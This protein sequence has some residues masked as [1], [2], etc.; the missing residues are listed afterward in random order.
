M[1]TVSTCCYGLREGLCIVSSAGVPR[2]CFIHENATIPT[3][4]SLRYLMPIKAWQLTNQRILSASERSSPSL[5][6]LVHTTSSELSPIVYTPPSD[7]SSFCR[8]NSS[9]QD[10]FPRLC[11][12]QSPLYLK[13]HQRLLGPHSHLLSIRRSRPRRWHPRHLRHIRA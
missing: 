10:H 6:A 12:P 9:I 8:S 13:F 11:R 2:A 4:R 3:I 1:H 5:A 7:T